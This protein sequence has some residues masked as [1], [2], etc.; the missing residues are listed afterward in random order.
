MMVCGICE[1]AFATKDELMQHRKES[2]VYNTEFVQLHA[3]HGGQVTTYRLFFETNIKT[4]DEAL[5]IGLNEI[6]KLTET[7]L[8]KSKSFRINIVYVIELYKTDEMGEVCRVQSFPFRASSVPIRFLFQDIHQLISSALGEV[9]SSIDEFLY[10][11]SGWRLLGPMYLEVQIVRTRVFGGSSATDCGLHTVD[12]VRNKGFVI[13]KTLAHQIGSSEDGFCIYY[14]LASAIMRTTD[15]VHLRNFVKKMGQPAGL[16]VHPD[17]LTKIEQDE[18]WLRFKPAIHVV[19]LDEEDRNILP[20][21]ASRVIDPKHEIVLLLFHVMSDTAEKRLHYVWVKNKEDLFRYRENKRGGGKLNR[22]FWPCFN[23]F[24]IHFSYIA[25]KNHV[26]W[27]N[28]NQ[29]RRVIMPHRGEVISFDKNKIDEEGI[30]LSHKLF[31]KAFVAFLDI[32]T[33]QVEAT[34]SCSCP[35]YVLI[36]TQKKEQDLQ[37]WEQLSLDGKIDFA[38]DEYM[39][40]SHTRK[41]PVS[42]DVAVHLC[43]KL[44]EDFGCVNIMSNKQPRLASSSS[45]VRARSIRVCRHKTK[46]RFR[47]C[48]FMASFILCDRDWKVHEESTFVGTDCVEQ[49]LERLIQIADEKLQTLSP[50][51]PHNLTLAEQK[52]MKNVLSVRDCYLCHRIMPREDRVIDHD[53]LNGKVLGVAHSACNLKRRELQHLTVFTHNLT[54]FDSHLIITALA[55]KPAGLRI[56]EGIPLNGER[57]KCLTVNGKIKFLDSYSF[58]PSSLSSLVQQMCASNSTFSMLDGMINCQEQKKLLL[59]KGVYP[60]GYATSIEKLKHTTSLPPPSAFKNDLDG[61]DISEEDYKHAQ[62]VWDA[63]QMKNM[64]DYTFI[65]LQSDVRLL[66]QAMME[67]RDNIWKE[68]QLDICSYLSLP[69][70][71]KVIFFF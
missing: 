55:K 44:E 35:E 49:C 20:V 29:P 15:P 9:D 69:M 3:H 27:C 43:S 64:I 71:T 4:M 33:L 68:F 54:G 30:A 21:R 45:P 36:N 39:H 6:V 37:Q 70:I 19:Y 41:V 51:Q 11:G 26:E 53:H 10:M 22:P 46:V 58:L 1:E 32:E 16:H 23:C 13:D 61:S 40:S 66:A 63:F 50:G 34:A 25:Y 47:H 17:D 12:Y 62:R 42:D 18:K 7:E 38:I 31:K 59:R 52:Q 2:H 60:Y 8:T 56:V 24:G 48:A 67:L 65:Y 57:F 28:N 14:A 5:T